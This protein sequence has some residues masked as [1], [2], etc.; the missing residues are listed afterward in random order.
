MHNE[1]SNQDAP[2]GAVARLVSVLRGHPTVFLAVLA[3]VTIVVLMVTAAFP[4]TQRRRVV[5][6]LHGIRKGVVKGDAAAVLACVS[7]YF[8][9]E[10]MHKE[11]LGKRLVRVLEPQPLCRVTLVVR[12]VNVG[13]GTAAA[14]VHVESHRAPAFGGRVSRSIWRVSLERINGRWLVR[15]ATP[16]EVNGRRIPGLRSILY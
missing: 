16:L 10:G 15:G 3:C 4:Q 8:S 5:G 9:E 1:E 7:P 6:A 14:I 11:Q 2:G 13:V 12:Q